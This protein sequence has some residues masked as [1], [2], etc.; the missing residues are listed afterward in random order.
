MLELHGINTVLLSY[1]TYGCRQAFCKQI[2]A[3]LHLQCHLNIA[4][5]DYGLVLYREC[6]ADVSLPIALKVAS[7]FEE[8]LPI[9]LC[10]TEAM[11]ENDARCGCIT[12]G[13]PALLLEPL[14]LDNTEHSTFLRSD[15][16]IIAIASSVTQAILDWGS[17]E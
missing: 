4:K 2:K 7:Q 14:F 1:D 6:D 9:S 3:D 10:K 11:K 15:D 5:G 13:I 12:K 17:N 16:G 8:N